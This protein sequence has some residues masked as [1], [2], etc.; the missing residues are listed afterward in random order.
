MSK[1]GLFITE[2]VCAAA[3]PGSWVPY[4]VLV[5]VQGG[6]EMRPRTMVFGLIFLSFFLMSAPAARADTLIFAPIEGINGIGSVLGTD[7]PAP[8]APDGGSS[9]TSTDDS[10]GGGGCG[11]G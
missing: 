4:S 3:H 6:I 7:H 11:G 8:P 1:G 9:E 5:D 10:Q 2:A